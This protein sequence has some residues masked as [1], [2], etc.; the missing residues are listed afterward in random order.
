MKL[1]Y[2]LS[3]IVGISSFCLLYLGLDLN[4]IFSIVVSLV[5]YY[6]ATMIFKEKDELQMDI[7]QDLVKYEKLITDA[8]A[9]IRRLE[10]LKEKI[11][12]ATLRDDITYVC[13]ISDRILKSLKE[14][15]KKT[16]Q[17]RKFIDYY[18][19][20]TLNILT[21]YNKIEDQ[22]LTS[23]ESKEFMDKVEMMIGRVKEAC[24]IQLNNMYES[25]LLNTNADIKVFETMLKT[26]GLVDDNMNIKVERK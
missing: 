7:S 20:F 12:N 21:Q 9:N 3:I 19:P 11:E 25:D 15:P 4:I 16:G 1:S 10:L 22:E 26:D 8:R 18:L 6:A 5:A 2:L 23:I 13:D 24:E 17:V 14:N